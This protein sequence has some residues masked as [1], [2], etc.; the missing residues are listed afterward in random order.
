M[1]ISPRAAQQIADLLTKAGV[2]AG[3]AL[4]VA[5]RL[6]SESA[7]PANFRTLNGDRANIAGS[8]RFQTREQFTTP[9][10]RPQPPIVRPEPPPPPEIPPLE[11]NGKPICDILEELQKSLVKLEKRVKVIED[12]LA[13]T[14]EC[15][16]D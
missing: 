4:D 14:V 9:E 13:N 16:V 10:S 15:S 12:L 11:C 6:L 5:Q 7:S 3:T 8:Q 2:P 1:P